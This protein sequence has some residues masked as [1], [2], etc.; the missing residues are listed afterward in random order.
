[1]IQLCKFS[2]LKEDIK[3][4]DNVN[5]ASI[6]AYVK[7]GVAE[8]RLVKLKGGFSIFF[9]TKFIQIEDAWQK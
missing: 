7:L 6:E 2:A 3:M 9:R 5:L 4:M 8:C 1:M